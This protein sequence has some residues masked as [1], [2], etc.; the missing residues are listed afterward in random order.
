MSQEGVSSCRILMHKLER[1]ES[2]A[3]RGGGE[4]GERGWG[5]VPAVGTL[6]NAKMSIPSMSPEITSRSRGGV[7]PR[8]GGTPRLPPSAKS[9]ETIQGTY[10]AKTDIAFDLVGVSRDRGG[11]WHVAGGRCERV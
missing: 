10:E 5:A 2:T 3:A 9:G 1:D 4:G 11:R 6:Q 8:P 7:G